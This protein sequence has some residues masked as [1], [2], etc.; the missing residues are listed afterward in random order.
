MELT[1]PPVA[2]EDPTDEQ[3][4]QLMRSAAA[5]ARSRAVVADQALRAAVSHEI[6]QVQQ[7]YKHLL[8]E[9]N[10]RKTIFGEQENLR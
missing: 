4:E 3:L 10:R 1:H 6:S 9:I 2:G 7:Q 8:R 5:D